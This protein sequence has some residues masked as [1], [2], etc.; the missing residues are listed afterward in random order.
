VLLLLG[1][2]KTVPAADGCCCHCCQLPV[3]LVSLLVRYVP[4]GDIQG[5]Y[6]S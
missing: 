6:T 5:V 3:L 1:E 4:G 2:T